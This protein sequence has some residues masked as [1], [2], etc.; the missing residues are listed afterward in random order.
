MSIE[1]EINETEQEQITILI[2][3]V[4]ELHLRV[5]ALRE[6]QYTTIRIIVIFGIAISYLIYVNIPN[7][8]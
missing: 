8:I 2:S 5:I 7:K 1:L 6:T 3:R 4:N